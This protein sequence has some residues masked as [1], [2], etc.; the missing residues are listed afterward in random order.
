MLVLP[1]LIT[2]QL[3]CFYS[4]YLSDMSLLSFLSQRWLYHKTTDVASLLL[5]LIIAVLYSQLCHF[6]AG[7]K[8]NTNI[9]VL[10]NI[11]IIFLAKATRQEKIYNN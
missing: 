3:S 7:Q 8:F 11:R 1:F 9:F 6:Q 5:I 4:K 10:K 2:I